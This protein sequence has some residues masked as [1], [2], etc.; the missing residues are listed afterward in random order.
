[1]IHI[2]K[3]CRWLDYTNMLKHDRTYVFVKVLTSYLEVKIHLKTSLRMLFPAVNVTL[4]DWKIVRPVIWADIATRLWLYKRIF[5]DTNELH[6]SLA[7]ISNL[8][9]NPCIIQLFVWS[10]SRQVTP[11]FSLGADS[12]LKSHHNCATSF[13]FY[14]TPTVR[15]F[16]R[17]FVNSLQQ[18]H[19]ESSLRYVFQLFKLFALLLAT[20]LSVQNC[21]LF[22]PLVLF[23]RIWAHLT[24]CVSLLEHSTYELSH[25]RVVAPWCN[26]TLANFCSTRK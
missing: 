21:K 8:P 26:H 24:F 20:L 22:I 1:M 16:K 4:F 13:I 5:V 19:I 6:Q 9:I 14:P 15:T 12:S 2:N 10:L 7:K 3:R 25:F 23:P 11:T 18:I 17:T